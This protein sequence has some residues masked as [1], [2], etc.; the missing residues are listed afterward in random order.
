MLISLENLDC[1]IVMS[2][3][4]KHGDEIMR[5]TMTQL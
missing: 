1:K 2:G 5:L 3:T 4:I